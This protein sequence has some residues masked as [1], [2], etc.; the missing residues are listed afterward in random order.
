MCVCVLHIYRV[1]TVMLTFYITDERTER[2][3][4]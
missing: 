4:D 2:E 3:G 1:T